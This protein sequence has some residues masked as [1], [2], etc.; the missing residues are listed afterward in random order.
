MFATGGEQFEVVVERIIVDDVGVITEGQ[1]KQV[2]TS[3]SLRNMGLTSE[4]IG[5]LE[6][7]NLWLSNTQLVTVWPA[8]PE[9]KLVGEDIYFACA[10]FNAENGKVYDLDIFLHGTNTDNLTVTEISV[11]KENGTARYGWQEENEIWKK[12]YR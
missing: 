9:A 3:E 12:I 8:D 7:H 5:G 6:D 10:D 2:Y 1:V 4:S 11:H